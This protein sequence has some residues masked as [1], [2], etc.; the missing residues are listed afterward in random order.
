MEVRNLA[1]IAVALAAVWKIEVWSVG[2]I[3]GV[4]MQF[5]SSAFGNLEILLDTDVVSSVAGA[6]DIFRPSV[7]TRVY[8]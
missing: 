2:Y 8:T 4:A 7:P 1:K 5:Q 3:E 6:A